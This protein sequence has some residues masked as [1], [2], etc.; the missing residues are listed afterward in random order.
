MTSGL[1]CFD[2]DGPINRGELEVARKRN[3]GARHKKASLPPREFSDEDLREIRLQTTTGPRECYFSR[4]NN[5][6]C[7]QISP[8]FRQFGQIRQFY[9]SSVVGV[10][11]KAAAIFLLLRVLNCRQFSRSAIGVQ[12]VYIIDFLYTQP[13]REKERARES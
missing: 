10:Y 8:S 12:N 4:E 3:T 9:E 13:E 7:L 2:K 5:A 1:L 6:A 11:W